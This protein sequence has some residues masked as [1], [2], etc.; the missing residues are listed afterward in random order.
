MLHNNRYICDQC[1]SVAMCLIIKLII[2]MAQGRVH[3]QTVVI[4][5]MI[6]HNKEFVHQQNNYQLLKKNGSITVIYRMST[7]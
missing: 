6:F 4:L 2:F 3:M 1:K 5:V 7:L